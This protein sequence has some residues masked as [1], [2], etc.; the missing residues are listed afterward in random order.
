MKLAYHLLFCYL[1]TCVFE[2]A[3]V[4]KNKT[5]DQCQ[6]DV[7]TLIGGSVIQ[8]RYWAKWIGKKQHFSIEPSF[9]LFLLFY[10]NRAAIID[11]NIYI[12]LPKKLVDHRRKY[13]NVYITKNRFTMGNG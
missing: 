11:E 10:C 3:E 7:E 13:V 4:S 9:N 2:L 6:L 12:F 8:I 1:H 5:W